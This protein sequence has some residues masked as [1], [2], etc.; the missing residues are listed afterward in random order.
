MSESVSCLITLESMFDRPAIE[1]AIRAA[2]VAFFR[3]INIVPT[4][5]V[6]RVRDSDRFGIADANAHA[7]AVAAFNP[8][9]IAPSRI[10]PALSGYDITASGDH[11]LGQFRVKV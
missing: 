9:P 6:G 2:R 4:R 7:E 3:R 10:K 8:P 11:R 5:M 1:A